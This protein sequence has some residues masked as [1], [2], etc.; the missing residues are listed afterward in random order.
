[1]GKTGFEPGSV[2]G[3]SQGKMEAAGTRRVGASSGKI[4]VLLWLTASAGPMVPVEMTEFAEVVEEQD[5]RNGIRCILPTQ[6]AGSENGEH[7]AADAG[8][9]HSMTGYLQSQHHTWESSCPGPASS[10]VSLTI[11]GRLPFTMKMDSDPW[12]TSFLLPDI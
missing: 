10:Q 6:P 7:G 2:L 3:L 11:F 12:D 4:L 1:M 8:Q 9:C 5:K